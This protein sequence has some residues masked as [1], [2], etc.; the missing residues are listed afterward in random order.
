M[1]MDTVHSMEPR[2]P[3]R[4]VG[5]SSA[6]AAAAAASQHSNGAPR[7]TLPFKRRL[8]DSEALV[9]RRRVAG[10]LE[11]SAAGSGALTLPRSSGEAAP[12][13][14]D[15]QLVKDTSPDETR[16]VFKGPRVKPDWMSL[17][18]RSWR[19]E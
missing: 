11:A 3:L 10:H 18:W 14:V 2:T 5:P 12:G 17:V 4:H 1:D 16:A 15:V 7:V 19:D 6:G 13:L 9:E 8:E